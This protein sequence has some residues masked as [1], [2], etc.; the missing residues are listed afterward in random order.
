MKIEIHEITAKTVTVVDLSG[1]RK[2]KIPPINA[3]IPPT[4]YVNLSEVSVRFGT[5]VK[6]QITTEQ[7]LISPM[8]NNEKSSGV[9]LRKL[10]NTF[11]GFV[12]KRLQ[13]TFP[14]NANHIT[15]LKGNLYLR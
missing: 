13:L 11:F 8:I 3:E 15:K 1:L 12:T 7:V 6:I 14:G 9:D 5:P 10:L 4:K 2:A